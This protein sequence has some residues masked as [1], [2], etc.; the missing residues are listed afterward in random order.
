MTWGGGGGGGGGQ[1]V[2]VLCD[3]LSHNLECGGA[4][5]GKQR[6]VKESPLAAVP[7]VLSA[8]CMDQRPDPL[9]EECIDRES[10]NTKYTFRPSPM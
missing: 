5:E 1:R 4:G 10:V 7:C 3:H 9:P 6:Q 8:Y 2:L